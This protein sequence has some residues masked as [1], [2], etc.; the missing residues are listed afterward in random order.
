MGTNKPEQRWEASDFLELKPNVFWHEV[1]E[2]LDIYDLSV[3]IDSGW[4]KK[5]F[6]DTLEPEVEEVEEAEVTKGWTYLKPNGKGGYL[7]LKNLEFHLVDFVESVFNLLQT[8][9]ACGAIAGVIFLY[10]LFKYLEVELDEEQTAVCVVLYQM[11]KRCVIT[12]ENVIKCVAQGL[13]ESDY[14]M[15]NEKAIENAISELIK[16]GLVCIEDG[17]YE[18]TETIRF[19]G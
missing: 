4:L 2:E 18:V 7:S 12:D 9:T 15:L 16:I 6:H 19:E 3:P 10:R 14:D 1:K 17:R 5:L 8:N 11:T 13:R